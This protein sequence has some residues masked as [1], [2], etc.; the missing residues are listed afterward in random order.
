M[1][2]VDYDIVVMPDEKL[3]RCTIRG[4]ATE[5]DALRIASEART[6]AAEN[7][8]RLLYD[9]T[10]VSQSIPAGGLYRFPRLFDEMGLRRG[11]RVAILARVDAKDLKFYETVAVNAGHLLRAFTEESDA[12]AWL[13]GAGD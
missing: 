7:A 1:R 5:T 6:A 11:I 12:L 8:C 4:E 2:L 13:A 9:V 3:V 10:D